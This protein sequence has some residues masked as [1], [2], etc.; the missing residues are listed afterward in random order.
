MFSFESFSCVGRSGK[1]LN[2]KWNE[3]WTNLLLLLILYIFFKTKKKKRKK[4][5]IQLISSFILKDADCVSISFV[6]KMKKFRSSK[7][8]H[9]FLLF[10]FENVSGT[11]NTF[12]FSFH[13][14]LVPSDSKQSFRFSVFYFVPMSP[15][16]ILRRQVNFI[17]WKKYALERQNSELLYIKGEKHRWVFVSVQRK[18]LIELLSEAFSNKFSFFVYNFFFTLNYFWLNEINRINAQKIFDTHALRGRIHWTS[19]MITIKDFRI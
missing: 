14:R 12:F 6:F 16:N 2:V 13:L 5:K 1:L 10:I 4:V 15:P 19:S 7:R 17:A 3:Y 18:L 9:V 11:R 8:T